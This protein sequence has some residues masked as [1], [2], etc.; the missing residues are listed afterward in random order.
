MGPARAELWLERPAQVSPR[1]QS[2]CAAEHSLAAPPV[3][4]GR[5]PGARFGIEMKLGPFEG[6]RSTGLLMLFGT[7]E[8]PFSLVPVDPALPGDCG[9]GMLA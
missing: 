2:L 6:T 3:E 7:M 1:V 5:G 9:Q 4:A 8:Q